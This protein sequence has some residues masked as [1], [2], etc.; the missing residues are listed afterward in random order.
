MSTV[1]PTSYTGSHVVCIVLKLPY[2]VMWEIA[3]YFISICS[4]IE[5]T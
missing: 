4:D 2:N 3:C 5:N 1:F